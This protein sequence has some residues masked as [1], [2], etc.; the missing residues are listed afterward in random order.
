MWSRWSGANNALVVHIDDTPPGPGEYEFKI[1]FHPTRPKPAKAS[2]SPGATLRIAAEIDGS[3]W[4]RITAREATWEHK[5]WDWP[6]KVTLNDVAWSIQQTNV[7]RNEGTNQFLPVGVDFSTARIIS[8]KGRDLA[9]MWAER[10]G[11]S[12]WFA[13]NPNGHDFYEI[14]ISF[15]GAQ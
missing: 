5:N 10:D 14:V 6:A 1:H 7:L 12:V 13:D 9:T 4:L 15:Q 2:P 8:R 11:L 3:D